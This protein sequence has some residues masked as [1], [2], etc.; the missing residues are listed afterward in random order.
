MGSPEPRGDDSS[1]S[2]LYPQHESHWM[3]AEILSMAVDFI[4]TLLEDWYPGLGLRDGTRT[5][6]SIPYVNRVVPCPFC[7]CGATSLPTDACIKVHKLPLDIDS[8]KYRM[9]DMFHEG[10]IPQTLVIN[11]HNNIVCQIYSCQNCVKV[12][13]WTM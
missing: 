10:K 13:A 8:I 9:V 4:D 12:V 5:A 7:V 1:S 3:S 6:E 11:L 2:S